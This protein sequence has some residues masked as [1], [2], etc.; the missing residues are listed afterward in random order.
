MRSERIDEVTPELAEARRS[1]DSPTSAAMVYVRSSQG[2]PV[3]PDTSSAVR[4]PHGLGV[5]TLVVLAAASYTIGVL[6][7]FAQ[8]WTVLVVAAA[9][10][11]LALVAA[12]RAVR[13]TASN[14]GATGAR[15]NRSARCAAARADAWLLAESLADLSSHPLPRPS[16]PDAGH[17]AIV[18][19]RNR[20]ALEFFPSEDAPRQALDQVL[21][22]HP[23]LQGRFA[24]EDRSDIV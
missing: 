23:H 8:R 15:V 7:L 2:A 19:R 13:R 17:H 24:V 16:G 20:S 5:P 22:R 18:S 21:R 9:L 4:R 14:S 10:F 11:Q 12:C 3:D 6:A 1:A